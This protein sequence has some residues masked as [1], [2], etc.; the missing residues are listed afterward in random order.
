MDHVSKQIR[1]EIMSHVPSKN[2]STEI[3]VR[4]VLH[5]MGFRFRLH[6]RDLPG[7]PD[8]VLPKRRLAIFVHGC[9]WHGHEGCKKAAIPKS[10]V[11]YWGKKIEGN[12]LRDAQ[13]MIALSR[14]DWK[15]AVIWQ[16]ETQDEDSLEHLLGSIVEKSQECGE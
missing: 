6:R 12:R 3:K 7:H 8:I 9:F 13:T 16:C 2:T 11:E 1:S 5:R 14:L 10:N 15:P 4:R